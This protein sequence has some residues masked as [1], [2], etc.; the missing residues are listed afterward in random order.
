MK[1]LLDLKGAQDAILTSGGHHQ[2]ISIEVAKAILGITG[3][4]EE[5]KEEVTENGKIK[6]KILE[7]FHAATCIVF[8]LKGDLGHLKEEQEFFLSIRWKA[9]V[10]KG[11]VIYGGNINF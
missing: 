6:V 3:Q 9:N 10:I 11:N 4:T 2:T 5:L 8:K 1:T 7:V